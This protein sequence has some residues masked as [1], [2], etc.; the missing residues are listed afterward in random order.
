MSGTDGCVPFEKY[1]TG[2]FNTSSQQIFATRV[3][4]AVHGGGPSPEAEKSRER[5]SLPMWTVSAAGEQRGLCCGLGANSQVFRGV[6][7]GEP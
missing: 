4:T 6:N 1:M 7:S 5:V 2:N 3:I